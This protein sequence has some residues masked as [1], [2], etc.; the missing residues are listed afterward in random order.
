[1]KYA[2]APAVACG[3]K[4]KATR[5][6]S[7]AIVLSSS[8]H[9][10]VIDDSKLVKPV[11]LPFGRA[12]LSTKPSPTGSDIDTNTMGMLRVCPSRV[13]TPGVEGRNSTSSLANRHKR[14]GSL[15]VQ[16]YFSS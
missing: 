7:G 14:T 9:F 2:P 12:K 1:M 3:L 11:T 15:E 5:E 8:T 6:T 4:R 16:R 10:P 13:E